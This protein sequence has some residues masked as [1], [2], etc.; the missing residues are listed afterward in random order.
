MTL[1]TVPS[2]ISKP[3][4][5]KLSDAQKAEVEYL[6]SKDSSITIKKLEVYIKE[7]FDIDIGKSS[8]HR[9]LQK[10]GFRHITGRKRHYK[11]NESSKEEFKKKSTKKT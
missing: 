10:L 11:S 7:R 2:N 1:L 4:R 5:S 9:M 3:S 6:V 8:I